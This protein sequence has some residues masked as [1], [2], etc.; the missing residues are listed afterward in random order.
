MWGTVLGY[1]A[2]IYL[3]DMEDSCPVVG[4][5]FE[6]AVCMAVRSRGVDGERRGGCDKQKIYKIY[7]QHCRKLGYERGESKTGWP[8]VED[9]TT[10]VQEG[11][12]KP[13]SGCIDSRYDYW[14]IKDFYASMV[15]PASRFLQ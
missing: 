9:G 8:D 5:W 10:Y 15:Y 13:I 3:G 11:I 6:D 1:S 14:E 4:A 7:R 12:V 2:G